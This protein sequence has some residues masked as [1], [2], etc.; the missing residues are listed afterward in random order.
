M[1]QGFGWFCFG[2]CC[3]VLLLLFSSLFL[4]LHYNY[5][6]MGSSVRPIR[7]DCPTE[8][9]LSHQ[10]IKPSVWLLYWQLCV[11]PSEN[12]CIVLRKAL[13]WVVALSLPSM[14]HLLKAERTQH[15]LLPAF[16]EQS[17]ESVAAQ[18]TGLCVRAGF[19]CLSGLSDQVSLEKWVY[20]DMVFLMFQILNIKKRGEKPPRNNNQ[21]KVKLKACTPDNVTICGLESGRSPEQFSPLC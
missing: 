5:Q 6:I 8:H 2:F 10:H 3:L 7:W 12:L 21:K 18:V 11:S 9:Q 14:V 20:E 4:F 19:S 15:Q 13:T 1:P 17:K 16:A